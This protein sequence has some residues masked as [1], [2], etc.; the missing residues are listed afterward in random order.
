[1]SRG[2]FCALLCRVQA[3]CAGLVQGLCRVKMACRP[4]VFWVVQGVQ[5]KAP[6]FPC[7]RE[8][9]S[10]SFIPALSLPRTIDP[11]HP[12]HPA[13][14]TYDAA[15]TFRVPCTTPAQIRYTLHKSD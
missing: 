10:A 14:A 7:A 13:Q 6:T 4:R 5:G 9:F 8:D 1:M 12:A 2:D 11:A 3:I 15:F